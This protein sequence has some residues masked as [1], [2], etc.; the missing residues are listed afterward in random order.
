MSERARGRERDRLASELASP[1]QL[2]SL[3]VGASEHAA[4]TSSVS[5]PVAVDPEAA[6][7]HTPPDGP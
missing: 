5:R 2:A 4:Q 1:S 7:T 6:V 3:F